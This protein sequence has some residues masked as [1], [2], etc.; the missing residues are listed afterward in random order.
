MNRSSNSFPRAKTTRL[1]KA[2]FTG[3]IPSLTL[4][5]TVAACDT[6]LGSGGDRDTHCDDG[7]TPTCRMDPPD[8][9]GN[10]I[11]AYQGSCYECVD[12]QTCQPGGATG[13][14]TDA[15]CS[16]D[17]WCNP[18]GS[19]SCPTCLDCVPACRPHSCPSESP[20]ALCEMAR[21]ECGE[22]GV[23]VVENQ[24][25]T[26]VDVQT[27][28]PIRNDSCDDGSTPLCLMD[29]P[30]CD[31]TEILAH[32]NDCYVCVNPQTCQP[33]G[34]AECAG[35]IDCDAADWCN[36]CGTGSCPG[37]E[38]CV[39]SC[40]PHGCPTESELLC[41][42]MRPECGED[43]VAVLEDGCWICVDRQTCE[44]A[45]DDSCDDGT[46]PMCDMIPPDCDEFSI[47]AYQNECY[48]CVNPLTCHAWGGEPGCTMDA[49][50]A[51]EDYCDPC[52]TSSC[53]MCNDC[54][55]ACIPHGCP[56]EPEP[57][58]NMIRPDCDEGEVAI[59]ENGCWECVTLGT[60]Q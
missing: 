17:A 19:S 33:W 59:V 6:G 23:A 54:V 20:T 56:T 45:R 32:R 50:C 60:C 48:V 52:A 7:T 29:P 8:C 31:P 53:P 13:C 21:P 41:Y 15:D 26:C 34:E 39:P 35:D 57:L 11:L 18:C 37:C 12:P 9:A 24:C 38:D 30:E 1:F 47:L 16:Y 5:L 28:A 36:P 4:L 58:C 40:T 42:G 25:W 43:G 2:R 10:E 46:E 27:C 22:Y 49:Q 44:P 55:A 51:V 3:V 14:G